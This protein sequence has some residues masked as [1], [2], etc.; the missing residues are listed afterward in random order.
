MAR[1]DFV[2]AMAGVFLLVGVLAMDLGQCFDRSRSIEKDLAPDGFD[3]RHVALH[4]V[5]DEG[6]PWRT[7]LAPGTPSH[8]VTEAPTPCEWLVVESTDAWLGLDRSGHPVSVVALAWP[9]GLDLPTRTT[10]SGQ[11]LLGDVPPM[12]RKPFVYLYGL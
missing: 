6:W 5:L 12:Y 10:D 9:N 1:R 7:M 3:V 4:T 11:S 2:I 8:A